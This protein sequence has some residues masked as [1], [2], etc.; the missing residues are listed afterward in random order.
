MGLVDIFE[1]TTGSVEN[2]NV[3][4]TNIFKEIIY[5]KN[6]AVL[7]C[8]QDYFTSELVTPWKVFNCYINPLLSMIGQILNVMCLLILKQALLQKPSNIL[9]FALVV[10][11]SMNL[12]INQYIE[13]SWP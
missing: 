5:L 6:E 10:S 11:D 9:L 2:D 4:T 3:T 7:L 12:F 1:T 8:T 13:A